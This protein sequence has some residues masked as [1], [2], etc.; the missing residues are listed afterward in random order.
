[1]RKSKKVLDGPGIIKM[2]WRGE[3]LAV[4][5][6]ILKAS[7]KTGVAPTTLCKMILAKWVYDYRKK[8]ETA[9]NPLFSVQLELMKNIVKPKKMARKTV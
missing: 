2:E 5:S 7:E 6:Q 8:P 4:F 1:M 9:L 3:K